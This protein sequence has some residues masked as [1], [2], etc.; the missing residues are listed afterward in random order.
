MV[1]V[2]LGTT[3]LGGTSVKTSFA[4]LGGVTISSIEYCRALRIGK[5][6]NF[7][8]WFAAALFQVWNRHPGCRLV[9]CSTSGCVNAA[10]SHVLKELDITSTVLIKYKFAYSTFESG[11]TVTNSRRSSIRGILVGLQVCVSVIDHPSDTR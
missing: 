1:N 11:T 5:H 7:V 4:C 3:L 6:K 8:S 10:L 2:L 9:E